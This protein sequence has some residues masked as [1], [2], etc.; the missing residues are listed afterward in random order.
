MRLFVRRPRLLAIGL[1]A[2]ALAFAANHAEY[3]FRGTK[4]AAAQQTDQVVVRM[5]TGPAGHQTLGLQ[6]SGT[7]AFLHF[8]TLAQWAFNPKAPTPCPPGIQALAGQQARCVG[9]MYPLAQGEKIKVFCLLRSTQTCCYGP[10]PQFNQYLFVEMPQAVKFE[11]LTPVVVSG[12]FLVDPKPQDGYIYRMEGTSVRPISEDTPDVDAAQFAAESKLPLFDFALM[13][14]LDKR[15][16]LTPELLALDGKPIVLEAK[17]LEQTSDKPPQLIVGKATPVLATKPVMPTVFTAVMVSPQDEAQ[18]PPAWKQKAV[19]AGTL[20]IVRSET[21]WDN[22]IVRLQNATLCA[23]RA[24]SPKLVYA[25]VLFMPVYVEVLLAA[26]LL[27]LCLWRKP[28]AEPWNVT[29]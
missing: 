22:G 25:N 8:A 18:V 3:Y 21:E 10:K 7:S 2:L 13:A 15:K 27:G 20:Q 9:F 5:E 29:P 16:Q 6:E 24:D 12:K 17:V 14:E 1:P 4:A 23:P 28:E 11:R 19:F 26:A